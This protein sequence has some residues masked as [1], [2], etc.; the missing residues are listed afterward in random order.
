MTPKTLSVNRRVDDRVDVMRVR[1]ARVLVQLQLLS[2]E[3]YALVGRD[4]Y[5]RM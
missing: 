3:L 1:D 5:D 2:H 4:D